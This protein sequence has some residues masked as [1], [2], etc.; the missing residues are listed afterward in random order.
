[1]P[2]LSPQRDRPGASR[3]RRRALLAGA[4]LVLGATASAAEFAIEASVISAGGGHSQS[5]GGCLAID[6]SIGQDTAGTSGGGAFAMR[7]GF[8][9]ALADRPTDSLFNDGF[10]ECQ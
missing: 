2:V 8:W 5:T 4:A 7:S 6:A 9:A 10:Q 1:M 3:I